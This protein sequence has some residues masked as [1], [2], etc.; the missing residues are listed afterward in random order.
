M[1]NADLA[2]I[3]ARLR[4]AAEDGRPPPR[5]PFGP[6]RGLLGAKPRPPLLGAPIPYT[7]RPPPA[8]PRPEPIEA[9]EEALLLDQPLDLPPRRN[10]FGQRPDTGAEPAP[11]PAASH[12]AVP[13]PTIADGDM[14][15]AIRRRRSPLLRR[16]EE[17]TETPFLPEDLAD[18]SGGDIERIYSEAGLAPSPSAPAPD[19]P[20]SG[21]PSALQ[22]LERR[23]LEEH[24][25]LIRAIAGV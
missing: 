6:L 16:I 7:P 25:L 14:I 21:P 17:A 2:E 23:L 11:A 13:P 3:R 19:L 20:V 10:A 4:A 9:S 8:S 22:R 12:A 15:E 5:G 1:N 24:M 18:A